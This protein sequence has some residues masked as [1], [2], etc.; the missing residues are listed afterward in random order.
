[1]ILNIASN[2]FRNC[3]REKDAGKAGFMTQPGMGWGVEVR[4]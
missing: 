2:R 4:T 3:V 1:M